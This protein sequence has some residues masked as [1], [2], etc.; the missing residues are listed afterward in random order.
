MF[1]S[2][3]SPPTFTLL[4]LTLTF[5]FYAS[6]SLPVLAQGF[7]P[8]P[9]YLKCNTFVEGQG[10]FL[11]GGVNGE[12]FM[13]DL[14]VPWKTNDPVIKKIEGGP[15]VSGRVCAMTNNG[16]D[17]FVVS[18]GTG[19]VYNVKS[20]SWTVFQNPN[21]ASAWNGS[22]ALTDQETG[23]IYLPENFAGKAVMLSVDVNT[24]TVNTGGAPLSRC[25]E[26]AFEEFYL[27]SE[28]IL[29]RIVCLHTKPSE[30]LDKWMEYMEHSRLGS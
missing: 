2:H 3:Y 1:L 8:A 15:R 29:Q 11:L 30:R 13:L 4:T 7:R 9:D 12:N 20:N 18:K 28:V 19:Y 27:S 14:S 16:E 23:F 26:W 22:P 17:L 6:F 5:L 21:F 10:L 25:L 24:R